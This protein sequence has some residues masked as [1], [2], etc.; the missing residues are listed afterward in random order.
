MGSF[1]ADSSNAVDPVLLAALNE[2]LQRLIITTTTAETAL[3]DFGAATTEQGAQIDMKFTQLEKF[4]HE[5]L[6]IRN[7]RQL[8]DTLTLTDYADAIIAREIY[9]EF[10]NGAEVEADIAKTKSR[11]FDLEQFMRNA[12]LSI[13]KNLADL[14][15][16]AAP[17]KQEPTSV[18][19]GG[20][21]QPTHQERASPA[22]VPD[23]T[24]RPSDV[25]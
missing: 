14:K 10:G 23:P 24:P 22:P 20:R 12:L 2:W 17:E 19:R 13:N 7:M 9:T 4:M 5:L 21:Q 11:A 1:A 15:R 16:N 8:C 3:R 6:W 25:E 18:F